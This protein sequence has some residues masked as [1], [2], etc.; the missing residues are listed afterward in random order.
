MEGARNLRTQ[1]SSQIPVLARKNKL[2]NFVSGFSECTLTLAAQ[3]E[4][5]F[6]LEGHTSVELHK[7]MQW[8]WL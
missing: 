2:Y 8:Q 7:P 4:E 1:S 3:R 5:E 6:I